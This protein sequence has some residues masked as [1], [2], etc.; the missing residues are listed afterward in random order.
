MLL[1]GANAEDV[2]GAHM[3]A[4]GRKTWRVVRWAVVCSCHGADCDWFYT[5]SSRAVARSLKKQRQEATG[6]VA[7][8]FCV[9]IR[10]VPTRRKR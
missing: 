6:T 4:K 8:V 3:S 1:A 5:T 7:D 9:E 10:E 2:E